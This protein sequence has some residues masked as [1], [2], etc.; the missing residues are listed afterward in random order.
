[1]SGFISALLGTFVAMFGGIF[2]SDHW[3][4][5]WGICAAIAIVRIVDPIF[6]AILGVQR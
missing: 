4:T 2:V 3:G 1:M 6:D 5:S